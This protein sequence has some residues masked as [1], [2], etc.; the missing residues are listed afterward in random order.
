M[1]QDRFDVQ[2]GDGIVRITL[3]RPPLNIL[4]VPWLNALN[5]ILR[6]A[7]EDSVRVVILRSALPR[8]FSAGVEVRDHVSETAPAMLEA[9]REN[10]RVL[11]T[12]QPITIAAIGGLTLGGGA[13]LAFLCDLVV[14]AEDVSIGTPEIRLGAFPPVAAAWFPELC[15]WRRTIEL[16]LGE[17]IDAARAQ[18]AGLVSR[19]V[20]P[21]ALWP[22]TDQLAERIAGYSGVALRAAKRALRAG[23]A[24][25]ALERL[26]EAI[27]IYREAVASSRDAAEGIAAFL[28]KRAPSWSHR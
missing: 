11:L 16:I 4:D 15:G 17:S 8:A 26:D 13:E 21:P 3:N 18:Q 6:R 7:D 20:P 12:L 27:R 23:R 28:E 14:A 24:P 19:V 5:D 22:T 10:A 2:R 9:V 25:A 1:A